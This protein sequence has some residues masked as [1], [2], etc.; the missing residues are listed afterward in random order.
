GALTAGAPLQALRLAEAGLPQ[1][2]P[3]TGTARGRALIVRA[4]ALV[5]LGG[6]GSY[7]KA[8]GLCVEAARA[9]AGAEPRLARVALV[10][11]VEHTIRAGHLDDT[12]P[13]EI[14]GLAARL[15]AAAGRP[16]L[17]DLSLDAF[18]GLAGSTEDALPRIRRAAEALLDPALPGEQV[19]RRH[20]TGA[21][22]ATPLWDAGLLRAV[23]R[24]AIDTA[25]A[26]GALWR[27]VVALYCAASVELQ[28]GETAAAV[29]LLEE[30]DQ[31]R[32][33]IGATDEL[34]TVHRHP[35]LL[36]LR[37]RT[38]EPAGVLESA[39]DTAGWL[40]AGSIQSLIRMGLVLLHLGC[41]DYTRARVAAREVFETDTLGLHP[42]VLPDLVEAAMR[43]GDRVLA[44]RALEVLRVRATA[45]GTDWALGV[46]AR[47]EA[48]LAPAS[49]A[50]E[51]YRLAITRLTGTAARLDLARAHLLHGEW[52]RRQ[53]RR[54]DARAELRTALEMFER[55]GADGFA[56]RAEQELD[57]TGGSGRRHPAGV[58]TPQEA[59]IARLAAS[60][61]TNGEIAAQLFLSANTV[62]HHLR[63]V[64]R[65]LDVTS[66]RQL[67][68]APR[69]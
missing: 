49:A 69:D 33:A 7:G 65:K 31:A 39:L 21:V 5:M 2:A 62:D 46:L 41:G 44:G 20:L 60:G 12:G 59:A 53:R 10:E 48:L 25:R 45:A 9:L 35:E 68:P 14:A 23:W 51:P 47:A 50:E 36:A 40:G 11:A 30:S 38:T 61:A 27:L 34:W 24:R 13:A 3:A 15:S 66:R 67:P 29:A 18:L 52:L 57:A 19:L 63:K 1:E 37:S 16:T 26:S 28:L 22:L 6:A 56:A 42:R 58:L 43:S 4:G 55:I 32:A 8:S 64:F 54:R 17:A